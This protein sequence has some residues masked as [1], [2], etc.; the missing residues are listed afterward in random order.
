[1]AAAPDAAV[2]A[3]LNQSFDHRAREVLS[4]EQWERLMADRPT[5]KLM[6]QFREVKWDQVLSW[7][8][9]QQDLTLVMDRTPPGTFTYSDT[10]AYSPSQAIDLLNSVLMTRGYTLVREKMLLVME[11][12]AAA[13]AT[14]S[15]TEQLPERGRFELVSVMFAPDIDRSIRCSPKSSLTEQLWLGAACGAQSAGS[16]HRRQDA[17]DHRADR[18]RSD[19]VARQTLPPPAPWPPIPLAPGPRHH[20][21]FRSATDTQREHYGIEHRRAAVVPLSRPRSSAIDSCW[22]VELSYPVAV[23]GLCR[24]GWSDDF[25]SQVFG[26]AL[27]KVLVAG[28]RGLVVAS[29]AD[30]SVIESSLAAK[31]PMI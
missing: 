17:D 10:R 27:A 7:F 20:T 1:M 6:F 28:D 4:D 18:R 5:Q 30:Q 29:Q 11:L 13:G 21:G 8:A 24:A 2:R 25:R 23:R 31:F 19:S 14:Q 22:K 26:L 3:E 16:R 12:T 15:H 9:G